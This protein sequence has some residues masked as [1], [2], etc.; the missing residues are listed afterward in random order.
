MNLD[1]AKNIIPYVQKLKYT[2]EFIVGVS[3]GPYAMQIK[4]PCGMQYDFV[5][6]KFIIFVG[7]A[8]QQL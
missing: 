4:N 8:Y 3:I 2:K 7:G 1:V 5:F 6:I